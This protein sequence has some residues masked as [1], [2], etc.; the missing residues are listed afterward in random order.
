[1]KLKT[2]KIIGILIIIILLVS[3]L[4]LIL[5][6]EDESKIG[7][8][9]LTCFDKCSNICLEQNSKVYTFTAVKTTCGCTCFNGNQSM[10][11]VDK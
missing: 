6:R 3:S 10:F 7:K 1:M 8:F 2:H 11:R 5:N 9:G 4:L